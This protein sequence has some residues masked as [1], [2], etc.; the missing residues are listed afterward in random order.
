MTR[1]PGPLRRPPG[2]EER[3]PFW[4]GR[5]AA[6]I[7]ADRGMVGPEAADLIARVF[8]AHIATGE[9]GLRGVV[10]PLAES[11]LRMC[12]VVRGGRAAEG[13]VDEVGHSD[14]RPED[15][16]RPSK[17]IDTTQVAQR[18]Q[19]STRQARRYVCDDQR[20]GEPR[21]HRGRWE[22]EAEEVEAYLEECRSTA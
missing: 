7:S 17:W 6:A 18:L 15:D 14:V 11:V 19:V 22:V 21:W 1:R 2:E 12:D 9:P 8:R 10:S 20:F 13:A 4:D 3:P 5:G 16:G